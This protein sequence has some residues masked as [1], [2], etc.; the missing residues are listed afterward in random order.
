M[1]FVVRTWAQAALAVSALL[2]LT[3]CGT[4]VGSTAADS[5]S[6][7]G[8][9]GSAGQISV[10]TSTNVWG[11]VAKQIGAEQVAV[12]SLI[13]DPAADPHSFEP[14]AQAQLAL[15]KADLVVVNGGGYDDFAR[16]MLD[17]AGGSAPVIDAVEVSGLRAAGRPQTASAV[18]HSDQAGYEPGEFN[19]HVWYDLPTVDKV[20]ARIAQE[21]TTIRPERASVFKANLATFSDR[22][23]G[24]TTDAAAIQAAFAGTKVA[25]TESLPLYLTQAAGLVNLTPDEFSRAIEQ[26]TDVPPAA[27]SDTLALLTDKQVVALVYN[28][29]TSSPQT[30]QVLA[31]AEDNSINV[32]GVRETLPEGKDY[33]S[34]MDSNITALAGA[35]RR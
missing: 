11:D 20:A 2:V 32:V 6:S 19:E 8:N 18:A 30:E 17:A 27:M 22:V 35:L 28:E 10:V 4:S 15:S 12:T 3:A 21:L 34:W 25:I 26:G 16:T 7:T 9:A 31:A 14:S 24:L 13:S 1:R 33:L 5:A 29:Q 23:A